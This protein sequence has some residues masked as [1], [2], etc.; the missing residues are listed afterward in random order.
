VLLSIPETF[1][2]T[3]II[4]SLI[5]NVPCSAMARNSRKARR[6]NRPNKDGF[7]AFRHLPPCGA[8]GRTLSGDRLREHSYRASSLVLAL[9][10]IQLCKHVT[11]AQKSCQVQ[12]LYAVV[13]K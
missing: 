2:R 1:E 5:V 4:W 7:E 3:A 6:N 12:M 9:D 8:G 11:T 13:K 10:A